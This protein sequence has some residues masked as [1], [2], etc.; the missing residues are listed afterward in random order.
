MAL[1]PGA[2]AASSILCRNSLYQLFTV[3]RFTP[4][5][6][7]HAVAVMSAQKHRIICL[8]FCALNLLYFI[9]LFLEMLVKN[10]IILQK[11]LYHSSWPLSFPFVSV[12]TNIL[13]FSMA[14]FYPNLRALLYTIGNGNSE[15]LIR[16]FKI[17]NNEIQNFKQ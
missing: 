8:C 4:T 12:G 2:I 16:K 14:F 5:I 1:P 10:L 6:S 9:F 3:L 15:F 13:D 17:S 11:I 7:A